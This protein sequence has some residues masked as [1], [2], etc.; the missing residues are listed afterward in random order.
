MLKLQNDN[1][2]S[3]T[4]AATFEGYTELCECIIENS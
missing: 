3:T 1:N 2:F 4:H